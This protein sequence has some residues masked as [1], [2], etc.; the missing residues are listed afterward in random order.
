MVVGGRQLIRRGPYARLWWSH[1]ITSIGDWVTL[2]A[3]FSLAAGIAGGGRSASIGIL[4][5]LLARLLPGFAIGV[6]GGVLAD[7]WDR[8]KTMVISDFGRAGLVLVLVFVGTYRD[9]FIVTFLIEVL[10]L[11]RQPARESVVPQ[12][13][14]PDQLLAVNGLNLMASYG[15]APIGSALFAAFTA[16]GY[17][18]FGNSVAFPRLAAAF[19]FDA[20][21]FVVSGLIIVSMTLPATQLSAERQARGGFDLRAPLRDLTDGFRFVVAFKAVRR[22]VLGIAA[23]LFGGGALFVLGQPYSEQVLGGGQSGFGILVTALGVG[24]GIG[25]AAVTVWGRNL[26]RREP[27]FGATLALTGLAIGFTGLAGTVWGAA[28]WVLVAGMGTGVAYVTG[29]THLHTVVTDDIRGRTFAALFAT[30]RAALLISLGL[31]GIG[32]AALEGLLPGILSS[33]VRS[34]IILSGIVILL[35]GAVALWA[36]RGQLAGDPLDDEAYQTLH[37]ARD[38]FTWMRG[39]RR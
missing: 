19:T 25:M 17:A 14:P 18:L 6:V 11:I 5:A 1:L 28:G 32:S 36:V 30:A 22:M 9:L 21:T 24:V 38:A 16:S 29:F 10:S 20:V 13:V 39:D 15:T 23:G 3:T 2:F 26:T 12:L 27:L 37:E 33:G 31:A 4:V 8:K 34:V 35:T 7:R